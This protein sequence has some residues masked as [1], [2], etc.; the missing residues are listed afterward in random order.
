MRALV[1]SIVDRIESA[2]PPSYRHFPTHR[3]A[4]SECCK[5]RPQQCGLEDLLL[6]TLLSHYGECQS[7]NFRLHLQLFLR[8]FASL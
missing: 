5:S 1:G 2:E 3:T 8:I 7:L 4:S 6:I